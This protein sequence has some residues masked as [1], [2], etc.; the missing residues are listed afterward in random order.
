[1]VAFV[2]RK[3]GRRSLFADTETGKNLPQKVF[4]GYGPGYFPERRL[5]KS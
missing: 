1:M 4:C 2:L 5:G 3:R